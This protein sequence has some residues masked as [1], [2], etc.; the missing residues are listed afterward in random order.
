MTAEQ[1]L[2]FE[3]ATSRTVWSSTE[4][5]MFASNW[6]KRTSA[7]QARVMGVD[8]LLDQVVL[9]YSVHR[10]T[11]DAACPPSTRIIT[12]R[13]VEATA[14]ARVRADTRAQQAGPARRRTA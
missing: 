3:C 1:W 8:E 12:P 9:R 14:H 6:P 4:N 2:R 10:R 5:P 7:R 13:A 11:T